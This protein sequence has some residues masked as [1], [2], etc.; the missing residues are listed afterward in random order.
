MKPQYLEDYAVLAL[1]AETFVENVP[2]SFEEIASREDKNEWMQ[3]VDEEI[4][5]IL[6][7]DTWDLTILPKGKRLMDNKWVFK[8][9]RDKEGNIERYKARL[10]IKGCAQ[11][12]GYDYDETYAPVARLTTL[13]TLLSIIIKENLLAMH[14]DVQNTFLHGELEEEIYMIILEGFQSKND[15]VCK[16]KKALYSLKQAPRTWNKTLDSFLIKQG[17]KQSDADR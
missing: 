1:N 6:K 14:M 15:L 3:A 10:V 12:Q 16:L 4:N 7:N 2:D 8:I 5:A 11:K 13:R 9:K 17:F